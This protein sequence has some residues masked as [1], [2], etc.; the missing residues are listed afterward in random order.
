MIGGAI[1][2]LLPDRF[3]YEIGVFPDG[4]KLDS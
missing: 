2:S 4:K 3:V 1:Y